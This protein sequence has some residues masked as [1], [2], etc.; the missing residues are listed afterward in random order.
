MCNFNKL[1]VLKIQIYL[2][3]GAILPQL[4]TN[5]VTNIQ[6]FCKIY[7]L[8]PKAKKSGRQNR[9]IKQ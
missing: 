7:P 3:F 8:I 4:S 6:R 9:A 1:E 2:Y 5:C